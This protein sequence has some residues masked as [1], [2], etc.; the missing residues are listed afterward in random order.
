[1][2]DVTGVNYLGDWCVLRDS[3]GR[4]VQVGDKLPDSR[5]QRWRVAGGRAPHK[6]GSSG[7]IH[8]A[9]PGNQPTSFYPS[10]FD[11]YW[12]KPT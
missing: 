2:S 3:T 10:V 11:C 7:G 8:V 9:L 4:V 1:M 6:P 5:G 12:V